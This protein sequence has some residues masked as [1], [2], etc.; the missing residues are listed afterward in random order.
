M[1]NGNFG[2]LSEAPLL[3]L[4][5]A[6]I[7]KWEKQEFLRSEFFSYLAGESFL[8]SYSQEKKNWA[9]LKSDA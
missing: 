2:I 9:F 5:L 3:T 1:L 8:L 4:V 6:R 7:S